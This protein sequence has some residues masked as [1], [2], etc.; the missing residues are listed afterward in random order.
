MSGLIWKLSSFVG[1]SSSAQHR[2]PE[3]EEQLAEELGRLLVEAVRVIWPNCAGFHLKSFGNPISC[4]K[5][6]R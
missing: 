3:E 4:F 2:S 5:E 1:D 6:S